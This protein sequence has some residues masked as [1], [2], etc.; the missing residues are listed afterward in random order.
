ML[1]LDESLIW[2]D[3]SAGSI[4]FDKNPPNFSNPFDKTLPV[5]T[6]P[7]LNYLDAPT[8]IDFYFSSESS[9]FP[10]LDDWT[11]TSYKFTFFFLTTFSV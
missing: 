11:L 4:F 5:K 3:F 1:F 6:S 7:L 2:T 8:K 10:G 9:S